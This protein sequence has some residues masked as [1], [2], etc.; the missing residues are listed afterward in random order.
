V[1]EEQK[2]LDDWAKSEGTKPEEPK[3][4]ADVRILQREISALKRELEENHGV[5]A[6]IRHVV[7][8]HYEAPPELI[9]PPE[10][11]TTKGVA[12]VAVA[13]VTD[14]QLGKRTAS[15]DAAIASK[16]LH[17]YAAKVVEF[18]NI[19]RSFAKCDELHVYLGG[20]MVEGE[21]GNY[22]SQPYDVESS[23]IRQAMRD[24][25]DIFE[26]IVYYWLK[27]FKKIHILGVPGNHGRGA[28]FKQTRN[29]ETNWDR[30]FYWVLH[31][32]IRGSDLNPRKD[33]RAR[34]T[35]DVPEGNRFWA[36]DRIFGWGNLIVHG[37]QIQGWAGIPYYGVQKKSHGWADSM[38]KD[39]D[40]LFFGHFHQ[41]ACGTINYRRWFCTGSTESDNN[42]A[43]EALASAGPPSQRLMF[44]T[45]RH[46]I[47]SDH[48][49]YLEEDRRPIM[50]RKLHQAVLELGR[51]QLKG[52]MDMLG[53]EREKEE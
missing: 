17:K 44:F 41:H 45:E 40:H 13:H 14:T 1:S 32:R 47:T 46:G 19:T 52:L 38:P 31:D 24:G 25:P 2:P 43:L 37:D 27:H 36:M 6:L 30:V 50:Q 42:Y 9:L 33:L 23:V 4:T 15:Y 49:I 51:D 12:H 8:Q 10:P 39:W 16:R 29:T 5:E 34:V 11:K 20:D 18:A 21:Y 22:P 7:A 53:V 26:G 3:P 48:Q 28:S 35:F